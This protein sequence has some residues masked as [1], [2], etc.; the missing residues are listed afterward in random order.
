VRYA[1][2]VVPV[3]P[4]IPFPR[5]VRQAAAFCAGLEAIVYFFRPSFVPF[6]RAREKAA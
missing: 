3:D 2:H 4:L 5:T 1:H 6:A